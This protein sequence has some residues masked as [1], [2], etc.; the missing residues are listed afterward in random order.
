MQRHSFHLLFFL[1]FLLSGSPFVLAQQITFRNPADS[2]VNFYLSYLPNK[3]PKGL[4]LL[5]PGFGET[6]H[7]ASFETKL[8]SIAVKQGL[9]C[10]IAI[11][12]QG[13]HAFYINNSSQMQL[14]GLI[15]ELFENMP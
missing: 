2:A 11:L 9:I 5:L 10:V 6:P 12:P 14:D 1:L 15:K 7:S 4:L 13:K 8:P 3:A